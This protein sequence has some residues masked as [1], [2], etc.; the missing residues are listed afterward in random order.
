MTAVPGG[1]YVDL[2]LLEQELAD[3]GMTFPNGLT[4]YE[5]QVFTH[6]DAGQPQ[7][8]PP[9]ADAVIAAHN[10]PRP[11]DPAWLVPGAKV[12]AVP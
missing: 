11:P 6:D 9:E 8:L 3:A 10:P 1:K 4:L 7:D 2:T 5:T 12:M